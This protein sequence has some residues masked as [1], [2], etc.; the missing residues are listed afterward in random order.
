[1]RVSEGVPERCLGNRLLAYGGW[2]PCF[3]FWPLLP[4]HGFSIF[5]AYLIKCATQV[6][7]WAILCILL[8]TPVHENNQ[9]KDGTPTSNITSFSIFSLPV[10]RKPHG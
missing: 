8:D 5:G 4:H 10:Q 3:S 2:H 9:F 1:M 6:C 7:Q